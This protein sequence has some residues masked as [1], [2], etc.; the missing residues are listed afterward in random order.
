MPWFQIAASVS[1]SGSRW[2]FST[3]PTLQLAAW[4]HGGALGSMLKLKLKL[5]PETTTTTFSPLSLSP[6]GSLNLKLKREIET[7]AC[8]GRM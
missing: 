6:R 7:R 3:T 8:H 2:E 1:A 4:W 5:K